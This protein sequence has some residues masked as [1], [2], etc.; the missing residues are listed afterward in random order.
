M[1]ARRRPV[2]AIILVTASALALAGP[3]AAASPQV[4]YA[5]LADNGKLDR[6]Y[7]RA[8]IARAFNLDR[9]IRTDAEQPRRSRRPASA[10]PR[11][12]PAAQ[13]DRSRIPFT[14]LDVALLILGGGPMLL[15]GLG[16]RRRLGPSA[17]QPRVVGN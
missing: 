8:D 17:G 6:R 2:L 5:D 10:T 16:L 7:S 15:I 13:P 12:E 9:V 4:I 1:T 3:A 14:G 11:R